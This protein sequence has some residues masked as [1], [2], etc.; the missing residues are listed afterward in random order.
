VVPN[1]LHGGTMARMATNLRLTGEAAEALRDAAKRSGRSQQDLLRE[2]VDRF[3]GL[4]PDRSARQRAVQAGLVEAPSLFNDVVPS[5]QL[6]ANVTTLVL[7]D[8]DNDR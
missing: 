4:N 5:I 6:P 2:A 8:R 7:L 3:L 1:I